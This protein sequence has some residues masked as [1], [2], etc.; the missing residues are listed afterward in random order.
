M[1]TISRALRFS[2]QTI[3]AHKLISAGV[4]VV[5]V[6]LG[7][8][9]YPTAAAVT[10]VQY[11]RVHIGS[12]SEVVSGTG[13]VSATS[14]VDLKPKVNA[15]VT[16]VL[17]SPGDKVT[18]GQVL[19]R[20]DARDAY[21][22]V[23]DAQL[24]LDQANVALAKLKEPADT[25]DILTAEDAI[26][27]LQMAKTSQ[28]TNVTTA[29]ANLLTSGLQA[30]PDTSYTIETAP[31]IT[32]TYN[33]NVEGRIYIAIGR[34][35]EGSIMSVSGVVNDTVM[36]SSSVAQPIGDTGLFIKFNAPS[37]QVNWI[38][39]IPNQR[40]TSYLSLLNSYNTAVQNRDLA[41]AD[42]DRQIA[43]QQ[44]KLDDLKKGAKDVDLQAQELTVQ[45]R[46]NALLDANNTLSD[47]TITAPFSGTM[48][49]VSA[50]VGLSAV[51]AAS[52]GATSLGTIV[53]DQQL[54]EITLNETDIAKIHLGQPA[55]LTFDA[56]DG[57]TAT[58]TV[59]DI[60][61]VG[62]V[63]QGVVTYK[64]KISFDANDTRVKP[65]M[66]VS[67]DIIVNNK[68]NVLVVPS[69]AVKHDN[70]VGYY[71][72][73]DGSTAP[74]FTRD[75]SSTSATTTRRF[76]RASSTGAFGS[77]TGFSGFASGSRQT[78]SV[79]LP[80]GTVLTKIPITIGIQGDTFTEV[81][82]GLTDGE[83]IIVKKTTGAT[84]TAT[85]AP[86]ITSLLRP[87]GANRPGG[88]GGAGATT[89]GARTTT[90]QGR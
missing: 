44:Q 6:G 20:L 85:Q 67:A 36:Y 47:Y 80:E 68:D 5:V 3:F 51:T 13:Q 77:S 59:A 45:Q 74:A 8:H 78:R 25:I 46:E 2:K 79:T 26:K 22:Q 4:A 40:S 50:Q 55:K 61:G 12:V 62:T 33:K 53:T 63:T 57:L 27:K 21:K 18:K 35:N 29:Y 32:G 48:A 43:E 24:N 37:T 54:A 66:S 82:S 58:G 49:S 87:G 42:T 10:T 72:E 7:Y 17:V 9:F 65:S 70:T 1:N 81:T 75:A 31:T 52:N 38:I 84:K 86:S 83:Q 41:N 73:S 69:N 89:G 30:V 28:D 71:V 39:D 34:G 60:D 76:N 15:N 23:R 90:T 19:F 16:S 11:G 64:V 88:T 14:Q 56:I